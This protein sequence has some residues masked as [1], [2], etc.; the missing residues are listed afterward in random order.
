MIMDI[1]RGLYKRAKEKLLFR[2]LSW[3][4][5]EKEIEVII[6]LNEQ[7]CKREDKRY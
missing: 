2:A 6:C 1:S 4:K 3:R 7:N 5:N